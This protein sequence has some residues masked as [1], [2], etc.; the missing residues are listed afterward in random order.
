MFGTGG[1]TF[2]FVTLLLGIAAVVVPAVAALMPKKAKSSAA[3]IVYVS[4]VLAMTSLVCVIRTL[5]GYAAN[6]DTQGLID[7]I[8]AFTICSGTL[9]GLVMLANIIFLIRTSRVHIN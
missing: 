3:V 7:T 5:Q 2:S 9:L 1:I 4:V 8:D 6:G